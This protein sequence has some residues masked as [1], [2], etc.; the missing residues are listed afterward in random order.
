MLSDSLN[1]F[2]V[3]HV[4]KEIFPLSAVP[5]TNTLF[6]K[7]Y[8]VQ[9]RGSESEV[10]ISDECDIFANLLFY[11]DHYPYPVVC[12]CNTC[13]CML[14]V[15]GVVTLYVVCCIY[16]LL[17]CPVVPGT[18]LSCPH[19]TSPAVSQSIVGGVARVRCSLWE[20]GIG[21]LPHTRLD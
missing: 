5:T 16:I 10:L 13:K 6:V 1:S 8:A 18:V 2:S 3:Y 15:Y 19:L 20:G 17:V 4:Y 7:I 21:M 9:R 14:Y 12:M 11:G